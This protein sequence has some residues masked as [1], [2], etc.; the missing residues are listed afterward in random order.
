M[1]HRQRA[2]PSAQATRLELS[3]LCLVVNADLLFTSGARGAACGTVGTRYVLLCELLK[4][5][6]T[7]TAATDEMNLRVCLCEQQ[8]SLHQMTPSTVHCCYK[9]GVVL[10]L[11]TPIHKALR[12]CL[13]LL[14]HSTATAPTA[15]AAATAAAAATLCCSFLRLLLRLQWR[16][17]LSCCCCYCCCRRS[18]WWCCCCCCWRCWCVLCEQQQRLSNVLDLCTFTYSRKR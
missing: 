7:S 5:C 15:T 11:L 4:R 10:N 3:S 13:P 18:C 6:A 9:L 8:Q 17:C 1:Q 2:Q 12:C 14:L 16:L